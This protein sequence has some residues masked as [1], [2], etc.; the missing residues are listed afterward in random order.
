[1]RKFIHRFSIEM[2]QVKN[3]DL[4]ATIVA[5]RKTPNESTIQ[6]FDQKWDK[7]YKRAIGQNEPLC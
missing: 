3:N 6:V 1:M 2:I 7:D 4:K 5:F